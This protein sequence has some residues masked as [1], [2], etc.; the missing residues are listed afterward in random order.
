MKCLEKSAAARYAS[1]K[2]LADDLRRYASDLPILARRP[3]LLRRVGKFVRRHRVP[4]TIATAAVLLFTSTLFWQRE[5]AARKRAQ[6]A[7]HY[8]SAMAYVLTNHWGN[9][10]RDLE[11]A[12]G[13][14]PEHI[15]TLLTKAWLKLEYN[16]ARPAEAGQKSLED[17]VT[18]C[19]RILTLDPTNIK[20]LGYLGVAL[21][22]L[23]RY[24]EAIEALEQA[25]SIN[26][27]AY[28]S[29]S[30]LGVLYAVIGDLAKAKSCLSKGTEL[31]GTAQDR[32]HGIIWRNLA[33]LELFLDEVEAWDH[34]ATA[35][36]CNASDTMSWAIR[37]RIGF[38]SS[39]ADD[40]AEAL[41]DAKH[42]D[43]LSQ[44]A[45]GKVKRV[46][47]LGHLMVGQPARAIEQAKLALELGDEPTINQLILA[48]AKAA[49]GD[50]DAARAH[51]AQAEQ[52]WPEP[53]RAAG[54]FLAT[55]ATGDLWIESADEWLALRSK[56]QASLA[57]EKRE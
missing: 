35:I 19:R 6:I 24:P 48:S 33:M 12:L 45:N 39:N 57:D 41:D 18:T 52:Y 26:E 23:E 11:A 8:D 5:S 14:D 55:A 17:A 56:A 49:A 4:V 29:W 42:A 16:R 27:S 30:N 36:G 43:R 2:D 28:F 34:L 15:Q 37:A 9:A 46:R 51:L 22:R 1:A 25:L 53:L 13:I 31:A 10:N 32:W 38:R 7:S 47:A 50:V 21:R 44:F 40:V 20:A 54:G 3:S